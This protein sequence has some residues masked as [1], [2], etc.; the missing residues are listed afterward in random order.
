MNKHELENKKIAIVSHIYATGPTHALETYLTGKT[1]KLIF[2]GH[3]FVFAKDT[4]SHMRVYTKG[5][6]KSVNTFSGFTPKNQFLSLIKDN[7]LT[8]AWLIKNRPIDLFVG[9]DC[10]NASVGVLLKKIGVVKKTA[11]WTIDYIPNRFPNSIMNNMYHALDTYCVKNSDMVWNLS[12]VM[13]SE[14]EKKG[15]SKEYRQKQIVVPMGTE[16][17][18]TSVPFAKIKRTTAVHMGHLIPK[19]G[20]Q[21]IIEAIPDI[22]KKVPKFHLEIIG[23][24]SYEPELKAMAKKY[25]VTKYITWHGFVKDHSEVEKMLS[26]GAYGLAPYVNTKDNYIQYTD[27]GKVKAYL[28]AGLPIIITKMTQIAY[29]I[30][31]RVCGVAIKYDKKEFVDASIKLLTDD[32]LLKQMKK[33]VVIM[34]KDYSCLLYTSGIYTYS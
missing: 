24:G 4:R 2:I 3:P 33:N 20:V 12:K 16:G 23:G 29:E 5:K 22:I 32:V 26:Y 27:P 11:F 6:S 25:N 8:F 10:F 19:Q 21:L 1:D 30:N 15:V 7:V 31:D 13:V 18:I 17:N 28:A 14:R 34:S 9:A